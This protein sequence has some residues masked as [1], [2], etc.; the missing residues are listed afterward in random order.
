MSYA[1]NLPEVIAE[2]KAEIREIERLRWQKMQD[3]ISRVS[4]AY[5]RKT[6]QNQKET[7]P[8]PRPKRPKKPLMTCSIP[9]CR[10]SSAQTQTRGALKP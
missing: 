7:R 9:T 2:Y 5:T 1:A 4:A 6:V 3:F 8:G 10:T